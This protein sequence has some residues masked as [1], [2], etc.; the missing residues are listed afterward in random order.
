MPR[1]PLRQ[2]IKSLMRMVALANYSNQ[3]GTAR[4]Q[5]LEESRLPYV[6]Q[7]VYDKAALFGPEIFALGSTILAELINHDPMC[8]PALHTA[9]VPHAFLDVLEKGILP[10][11]DCLMTVPSALV[12]ICLNAAGLELVK[13]R[14]VLNC[15]VPI[16]TSPQ[17][18]RAMQGETPTVLGAG[19]DELMRHVPS[20]RQDGVAVVLK[21]LRKVGAMGGSKTALEQLRGTVKAERAAAALLARTIPEAAPEAPRGQESVEPAVAEMTE[22]GDGPEPM[23]TGDSEAPPPVPEAPPA[24]AGEIIVEDKELVGELSDAELEKF[25]PDC[26]TNVMRMLETVLSNQETC[27]AF[28]EKRGV[29]ALLELYTL[30]QMPVTFGAQSGAAHSMTVAFRAFAPQQSHS[31]VRAV[32]SVLREQLKRAAAATQKQLSGKKLS[33]LDK[34]AR[35]EVVRHWASA[36]C[37]LSL[38]SSMVRSFPGVMGEMCGGAADVLKDMDVLYKEAV[39]QGAFLLDES[40]RAGQNA[41]EVTPPTQEDSS[42]VQEYVDQYGNRLGITD[43]RWIP[44]RSA[45]SRL[46]RGGR[47]RAV[48]ENGA[49]EA[50]DHAVDDPEQALA[51]LDDALAAQDDPEV[52][53][54]FGFCCRVLLVSIDGS[55][56]R[57]NCSCIK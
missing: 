17:Y 11:A 43:V 24:V 13:Q 23:D 19:L 36:E 8:Y 7:T 41:K 22:S 6:L 14:K 52:S 35:A 1:Y 25:L 2:L 34:D 39:W 12:A 31:L 54:L 38:A 15:L 48:A 27:R 53:C 9:R 46:I 47:A 10:T 20:L 21:L 56:R 3:Q 32:V 49:M 18:T 57:S 16:M 42:L 30:P 51:D 40:R 28:I 4:V 37:L 5:N 33:D 55:L 26:I 50:V 29:E 44:G 45:R